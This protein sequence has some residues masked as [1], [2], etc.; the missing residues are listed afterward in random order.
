MSEP[1]TRHGRY[2]HTTSKLHNWPAFDVT[3]ILAIEAE[4]AAEAAPLDVERLF[5]ELRH[6]LAT[7]P[8]WEWD[9]HAGNNYLHRSNVLAIVDDVYAALAATIRETSDE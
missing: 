4:A 2:V 1:T 7:T 5:A 8:G 3:D 6:A 9:E